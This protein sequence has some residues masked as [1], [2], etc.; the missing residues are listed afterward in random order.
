[1]GEMITCDEEHARG[2]KKHQTTLGSLHRD[3][4]WRELKE[5]TLIVNPQAEDGLLEET[6]SRKIS[7][8]EGSNGFV[9]GMT[10]LPRRSECSIDEDPGT[11]TPTII[12]Y[13]LDDD[14]EA[15]AQ[16]EGEQRVLNADQAFIHRDPQA[17]MDAYIKY[18]SSYGTPSSSTS[19][20]LIRNN[21][22]V[23]RRIAALRSSSSRPQSTMD[24]TV[25][26]RHVIPDE[27]TSS[28]SSLPCAPLHC[29]HSFHCHS[30]HTSAALTLIDAIHDFK[31]A[32]RHDLHLSPRTLWALALKIYHS[33]FHRFV[34]SSSQASNSS[35]SSCPWAVAVNH[36][37]LQPTPTGSSLDENTSLDN[38]R[39]LT[40]DPQQLSPQ[41]SEIFGI[42]ERLKKSLVS[43]LQTE[44]LVAKM[45]AKKKP[46]AQSS[47]SYWFWPSE[48]E[49]SSLFRRE[50]KQ[51]PPS[52]TSQLL[53]VG[54]GMQLVDPHLRPQIS[55]FD[56]L[57]CGDALL[58]TGT[59]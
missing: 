57:L 6:V 19:S 48:S 41:E 5:S 43:N 12:S 25:D 58:G 18:R 39:T 47:S 53:S 37:P 14:L 27:L 9:S 35:Q 4:I 24:L 32:F 23:S 46:S 16:E 31:A 29:V 20:H 13:G 59:G 55:L 30:P 2:L 11:S 36:L 54:Y 42:L 28:L 40:A 22:P 21:R 56:E 51:S 49:E 44:V 45:S 7:D 10:S 52:L 15:S 3:A 34:H 38:H 8:S 17:R 50:E 26:V 1:M 33:Q